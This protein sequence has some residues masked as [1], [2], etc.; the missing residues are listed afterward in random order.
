MTRRNRATQSACVREDAQACGAQARALTL[1]Y[2]SRHFSSTSFASAIFFIASRGDWRKIV[3][4]W[5]TLDTCAV[6]RLG[7]RSY[8]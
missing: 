2:E 1:W 5:T 8:R 3:L 6:P 7:L 4:D